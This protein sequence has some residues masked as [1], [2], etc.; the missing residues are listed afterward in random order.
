MITIHKFFLS[1]SPG[2]QKVSMPSGARVLSVQ[3]Q[4]ESIQVWAL[5]NTD[6]A[7]EQRKFFLYM[8][9]DDA[10]QALGQSKA[11]VGTVQLDGGGFVLHVFV[12]EAHG[13]L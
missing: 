1:S 6:R 5:V 7:E 10:T 12:N 13:K 9:G 4:A 3:N 2:E 8:T 11:F